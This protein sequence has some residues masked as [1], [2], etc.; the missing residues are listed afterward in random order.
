MAETGDFSENSFTVGLIGIFASRFWQIR[1]EIN[2]PCES[3]K[4]N[5]ALCLR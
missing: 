1:P 2:A 3:D 4:R 5:G